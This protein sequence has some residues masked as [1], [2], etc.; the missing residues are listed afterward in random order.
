MRWLGV[1]AALSI[2][3]P[4]AP[5]FAHGGGLDGMGCH[6]N[7]KAG[8]YHCHRGPMKGMSFGSKDEALRHLQQLEAGNKQEGDGTHPTKPAGE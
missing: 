2:L 1:L 5:A 3:A 7:R 8:G 4:S 6:H